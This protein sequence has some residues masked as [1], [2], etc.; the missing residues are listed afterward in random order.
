MTISEYAIRLDERLELNLVQNEMRKVV[1]KNFNRTILSFPV[2]LRSRE[3][4]SIEFLDQKF[5]FKMNISKGK[6]MGIFNKLRG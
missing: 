6:I 2:K 5:L 4:T 1:C 3:Q